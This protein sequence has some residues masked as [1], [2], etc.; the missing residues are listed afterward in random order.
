MDIPSDYSWNV[1]SL[2]YSTVLEVLKDPEATY[3]WDSTAR[4]PY[5]YRPSSTRTSA[6]CSYLSYENEQSLTEKAQ[7][8]NKNKLGGIIVWTLSLGYVPDA[9]TNK[10]QALIDAL[11]KGVV[12]SK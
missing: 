4:V 1:T 2:P 9:S 5:V 3:A 10:Q 7:Y 12:G 8:I 11:Y 6:Y